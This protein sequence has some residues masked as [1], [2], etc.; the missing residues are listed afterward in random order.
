MDLTALLQL[1]VVALF[2]WSL[3][4]LH[5]IGDLVGRIEERFQER[6]QALDERVDKL[7]AQSEP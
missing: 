3:R 7:E 5:R 2:G 6:L 4:E 1:V